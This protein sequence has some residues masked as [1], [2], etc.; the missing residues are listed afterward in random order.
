[1]KD[2]PKFRA[3]LIHRKRGRKPPEHLWKPGDVAP[4][5]GILAINHLHTNSEITFKEWLKYTCEWV[6][7]IIEHYGTKDDKEVLRTILYIHE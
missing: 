6:D 3:L 1:M 2:D 7:N 5:N 4:V